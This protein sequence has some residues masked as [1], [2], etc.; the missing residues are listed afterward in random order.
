MA[1]DTLLLHAAVNL[2]FATPSLLLITAALLGWSAAGPASAGRAERRPLAVALSWTL[3]LALVVASAVGVKSGLALERSLRERAPRR[4]RGGEARSTLD[5]WHTELWARRS[6]LLATTQGDSGAALEA[7][8]RAQELEP[9]AAWLRARAAPL[10]LSRQEPF[11]GLFA[12]SDAAWLYPAGDYRRQAG[13]LTERLYELLGSETPDSEQS[14]SSSPTLR[15]PR[16]APACRPCSSARRSCCRPPVAAVAHPGRSLWSSPC[17][18]LACLRWVWAVP[19][20]LEQRQT[21]VLVLGAF[22]G[23]ALLTTPVWCA[24]R[25]ALADVVSAAAVYVLARFA[26]RRAGFDSRL[27]YGAL[28]AAMAAQSFAAVLGASAS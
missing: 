8:R 14:E 21:L 15:W 1:A 5:P 6:E 3:G 20:A 17:W 10:R 13:R 18:A 24:T 12:L 19:R 9:G 28:I 25:G 11:Q 7:L 4:P 22:A 16:P 27:L 23:F 2:D 26:L